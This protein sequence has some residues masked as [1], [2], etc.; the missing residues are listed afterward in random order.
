L[1][2]RG[3]VIAELRQRV[4]AGEFDNHLPPDPRRLP[5]GARAGP[6]MGFGG[7]VIGAFKNTLTLDVAGRLVKL[8]P[9]KVERQGAPALFT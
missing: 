7:L 4:D 3:V 8:R 5:L 9:H 6:L 1:T 2:V